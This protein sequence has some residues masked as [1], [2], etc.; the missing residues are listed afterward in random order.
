MLFATDE[1]GYMILLTRQNAVIENF[2][3]DKEKGNR[4]VI[5]HKVSLSF[6]ENGYNIREFLVSRKNAEP[7]GFVE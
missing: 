3:D 2:G 6:L 7:Q 1:L 4:A 5:L